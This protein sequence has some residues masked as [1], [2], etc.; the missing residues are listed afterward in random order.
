MGDMRKLESL[1]LER[2]AGETLT[3][4]GLKVLCGLGRLRSLRITHCTKLSDRALNYLQH[5][6]GLESLELS[7]WDDSNF[8]DEGARQLCEL[9]K[10]KHL[11]LVGGEHLTDRGIYYLSKISTLETLNLRYVQQIT[12]E[13][14]EN[15]RYLRHLRELELADCS[16]TPRAKFHLRRATGA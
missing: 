7:C 12:D 14:L 9:Q 13:G 10:L 6:H 16:V 2:G 3:D 1:D 4:N 11:S 15:L 8:T 5:L